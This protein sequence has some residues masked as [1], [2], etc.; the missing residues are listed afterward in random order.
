MSV[1]NLVLSSLLI[2]GVCVILLPNVRAQTTTIT[3]LQ[4][5]SEVA[6]QNGI[7]NPITVT[8]TV[9]Y[10]DLSSGYYVVFGISSGTTEYATGSASSAP[11]SCLSLAGTKY[12]GRAVCVTLPSSISGTETATFSLYFNTAQQ[13]SLEALAVM[14]YNS[15]L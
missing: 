8:F 9:N 1:R 4:Y 5:Q 2:L 14:T 13:Y 12:D 15:N 11:D 7:T 3:N 10:A 6:L